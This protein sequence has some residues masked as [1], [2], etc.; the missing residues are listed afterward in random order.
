MSHR[1]T[2]G[3]DIGK[4]SMRISAIQRKST[5]FIHSLSICLHSFF[6]L[7]YISRVL[8]QSGRNY[9]R[10]KIAECLFILMLDVKKHE[11]P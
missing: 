10:K 6:S 3:E 2:P 8:C 9:N 5:K 4:H 11:G 7:F 1:A